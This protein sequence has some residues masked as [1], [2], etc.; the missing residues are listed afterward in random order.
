MRMKSII[1]IDN[2]TTKTNTKSMSNRSVTARFG[3]LLLVLVLPCL[4]AAAEAA[5]DNQ[6]LQKSWTLLH[7]FGGSTDFTKR[8]TI[9]LSIDETAATP[10]D[11]AAAVTMDIANEVE[12]TPADVQAMLEH[13]WYQLKIVPDGKDSKSVPAVRTSVPACQLRR[14]NFRYVISFLG[15]ALVVLPIVPLCMQYP[16]IHFF[17]FLLDTQSYI[18][19]PTDS[20]RYM[21]GTNSS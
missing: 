7:S 20:L 6:T 5:A 8:G 14:A 10:A 1:H 4:V 13:E 2:N 17:T 19:I 11:P 21:T 9:S 3:L 12:F 15:L 18:P 16:C